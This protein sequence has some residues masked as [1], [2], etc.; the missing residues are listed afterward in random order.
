MFLFAFLLFIFVS[1]IYGFIDYSYGSNLITIRTPLLPL[2]RQENNFFCIS[3][4]MKNVWSL[5]YER[6]IIDGEEWELQGIV[7]KRITKN[8]IIG[9]EIPYKLQT[10]GI[11]DSAIEFFHRS[12]GTTQQYRD[13]FP[14][15]K[16]QIT[17]EPY[18]Y[19]YQ[20]FDD[21]PYTKEMRRVYPR[22]YPRDSLQPPP[23]LPID[24]ISLPNGS[25]FIVN[26]FIFP[27]EYIA[28]DS[29]IYDG[30]DNPK[31]YFQNIFLKNSNYKFFWGV[32]SKIP[33]K[34]KTDYFSSAGWD[35][36][37]FLSNSYIVNKKIEILSGISYT[38]YEFKKFLW[39]RMMD[40]QWSLRFQINYYNNNSIYFFEYV[41]FN[42][43]ILNLGRLSEDSHYFTIGIKKDLFHSN[44]V[45]A[46]I[47]NFYFYATSPDLGLYFSYEFRFN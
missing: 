45:F 29:K 13:R 12:T 21:T 47:E 41:F 22:A 1:S 20:F 30:I 25:Y 39:I 2:I 7:N 33:I 34:N 26:Y 8:N 28:R 16:I 23:F 36:S 24:K 4:S 38:L 17:Y 35:N 15:N 14:K 9:V 44:F 43:P 27:L 6:Y 5:Q 19:L 37:L 31:M 42:K 46:M 10:G 18:G 40:H 3:I 32:Y 11:F